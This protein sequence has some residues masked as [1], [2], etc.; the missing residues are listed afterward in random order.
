[1]VADG[2]GQR[3]LRDAAVRRLVELSEAAPLSRDDVRL[4]AR[5]LG[6]RTIGVA[7]GRA[8]DGPGAAGAALTVHRG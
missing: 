3:V 6:V 8:G 5:G 4:A 2:G 1:M 7:L